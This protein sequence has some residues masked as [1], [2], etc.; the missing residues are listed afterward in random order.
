MFTG[1]LLHSSQFVPFA[2]V[3]RVLASPMAVQLSDQSKFSCLKVKGPNY[4]QS[5]REEKKITNKIKT[6]EEE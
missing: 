3:D 1:S 6:G 4:Q 5:N 2:E